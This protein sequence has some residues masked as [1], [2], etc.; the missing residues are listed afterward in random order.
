MK[1]IAIW[2]GLI[3]FAGFAL[4]F[5]L[6]DV[7]GLSDNYNLR[8]FNSLIHLGM[9]YLA[10]QSYRNLRPERVGNYISGVATGMYSSII[11]VVGF[12]IFMLLYLTASPELMM[13]IKADF[14]I[15]KYLNPFTTT[16]FI[17]VEGI[18]VSLIGSYIITRVIDDRMPQLE[19]PSGNN[20]W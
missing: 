1:R 4:F 9:I 11:G 14:P 20:S 17:F 18:A 6:M 7:V 13:Q 12:S 10:V 15:G 3:M 8:I 16:L 19:Y 2:Y 5:L